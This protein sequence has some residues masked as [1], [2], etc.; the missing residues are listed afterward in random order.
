M[1]TFNNHIL[2]VFL[3]LFPEFLTLLFLLVLLV[4]EALVA[5]CTRL[6]RRNGYVQKVMQQAETGKQ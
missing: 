3:H 1:N 5:D 4:H 2:L 6:P